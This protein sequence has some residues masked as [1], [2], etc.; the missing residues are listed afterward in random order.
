[1]GVKAVFQAEKC[2]ALRLPV[3]K[4]IVC[5]VRFF[6]IRKIQLRERICRK[7]KYRHKNGKEHKVPLKDVHT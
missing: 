6:L 1:M 7:H 5:K 4:R 2:Y 3:L